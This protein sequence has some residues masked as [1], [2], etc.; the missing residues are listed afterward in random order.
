M[1]GFGGLYPKDK[2]KGGKCKGKK[3]NKL[4]EKMEYLGKGKGKG[5]GNAN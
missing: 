5:R 3:G 4:G 1:A 2:S